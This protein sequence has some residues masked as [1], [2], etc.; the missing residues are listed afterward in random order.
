MTQPWRRLL[1][2]LVL[3]VSCSPAAS[4]SPAASR[5]RY[6]DISPGFRPSKVPPRP[7]PPVDLWQRFQAPG[8]LHPE[9][10]LPTGMVLSPNLLIFGECR[11]ASQHVGTRGAPTREQS[12][13]GVDLFLN[14]KLT[15]TERLVAGSSRQ[16]EPG[17]DVL[18]VEGELS[19]LWPGLDPEGRRPLDLGF[20]LGRTPV[21]VQDGLLIGDTLDA[22]MLVRNTIPLPGT[23]YARYSALYAWGGV[24]RDQLVANREAELYGLLTTVNVHHAI[25]DLDLVLVD[26]PSG[27]GGDQF[28]VGLSWYRNV[29][30]ASRCVDTTMRL[31]CSSGDPS[32]SGTVCLSS[33]RFSPPGKRDLV[34]VNGYIAGG[35]YTPAARDARLGGP[36]ARMGL[37][38]SGFSLAPFDAPLSNRPSGSLGGVAGYQMFLGGSRRQLVMEVGTAAGS[39]GALAR[40]GRAVGQHALVSLDVFAVHADR[41]PRTFGVRSDFT[42]RF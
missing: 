13:A 10:R 35:D 42:F 3:L 24:H 38:F 14:L 23:S 31:L 12:L 18:F 26:A 40:H 39:R 41:A 4:E 19:E 11:A 7:R 37:L 2:A 29:V 21:F 28:N 16:L 20:A 6:P 5:S 17:L 27:S 25:L 34:Y 15:Q 33:F 30:L 1:A 36:L 8:P 32:R 9:I 22:A